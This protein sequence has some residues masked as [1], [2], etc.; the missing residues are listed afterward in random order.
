MMMAE[1]ASNEPKKASPAVQ[2]E[3][4]DVEA[5]E[6]TTTTTTTTTTTST[7]ANQ[8]QQHSDTEEVQKRGIKLGLGDFVFYSVLV[9]RAAMFDMI[10]GLYRSF[11]NFDCL[12][13]DP[14]YNGSFT[15]FTCFMGIITGLFFTLILLA[16]FRKAL[17]A[18]PIS[19]FFGLVFYAGTRFFLLPYVILLGENAVFV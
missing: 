6:N 13:S 17:P 7:N 8:Q 4:V 9:G 14:F 5:E 16:I 11:V 3:T 12:F 19:I 15:V 2:L 1:P 18:L 10:T